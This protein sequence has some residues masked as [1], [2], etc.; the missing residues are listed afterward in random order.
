MK[1]KIHETNE[2]VWKT[3]EAIAA[4][5]GLSLR[6]VADLQRRRIL[7]YVKIGRMVRFDVRECERA[8]KRFEVKGIASS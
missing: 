3:R 6:Y 7:P 4:H 5:F 2:Q 1:T 8:L